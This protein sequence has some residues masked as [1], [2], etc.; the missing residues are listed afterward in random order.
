MQ[1]AKTMKRGNNS[2]AVHGMEITPEERNWFNEKASDGRR[3]FKS[4]WVPEN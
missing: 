1:A 4:K 2:K 3:R